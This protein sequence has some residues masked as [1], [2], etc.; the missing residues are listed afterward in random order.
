M[1]SFIVHISCNYEDFEHKYKKLKHL[2]RQQQLTIK[3][4]FNKREIVLEVS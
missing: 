4:A 3:T 2:E 1:S